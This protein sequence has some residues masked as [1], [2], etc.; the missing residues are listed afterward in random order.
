M[1]RH[2][3][4]HGIHSPFLYG[5]LTDLYARPRHKGLHQLLDERIEQGEFGSVSYVRS[6]DQL[7]KDQSEVVVW[8]EPFISAQEHLEWKGWRKQNKVLSIW[9][10]RAIVV[11][12]QEKLPNQH[13]KIRN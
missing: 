6:L 3:G 13:F 1:A 9:L 4:G 10:P 7:V 2:Y 8:E 12:R 5:F 11:F